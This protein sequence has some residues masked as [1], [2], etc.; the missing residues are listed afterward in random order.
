M[1]MQF[2][3]CASSIY[4]LFFTPLAL[5]PLLSGVTNLVERLGAGVSGG[6]ISPRIRRT[7]QQTQQQNNAAVQDE[8]A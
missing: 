7:Q 5:L 4:F 6:V 8:V 3:D 1:F 2:P